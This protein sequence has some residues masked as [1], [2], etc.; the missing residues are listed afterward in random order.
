[1]PDD[2]P[3]RALVGPAWRLVEVIEPEGSWRPPP[4][5]EAELR[6]EADGRL[7][8]TACNHYRGPV[9]IGQGTLRVAG[10]SGTRM[11]CTGVKAAV[12][13]AFVGVMVDEVRWE[14]VGDELRLDIP[15][16]RGLRY[17]R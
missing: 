9:E 8:A 13:D 3:G 1:M 17:A 11:L 16:G 14:V 5:V 6:F 4:G 7:T 2:D 15:G 10:L 12:E